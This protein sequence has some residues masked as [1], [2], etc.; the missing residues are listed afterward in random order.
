MA[1]A[2]AVAELP[3]IVV[4]SSSVGHGRDVLRRNQLP[5]GLG[6]SL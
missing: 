1:A 6:F 3:G 5:D 2:Y 4:L